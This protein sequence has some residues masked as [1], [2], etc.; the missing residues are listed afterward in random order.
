V[1]LRNGG[2]VGKT[3]VAGGGVGD[4]IIVMT[5][6]RRGDYQ[7]FCRR[8]VCAVVAFAAL[9]A[10]L[11]TAY[12]EVTDGQVRDCLKRAVAQLKRG[13]KSDGHW[14]V[15]STPAMS[16]GSGGVTAL[17]VFALLQ[18]G[19][20]LKD[21]VV[22]KGLRAL[23]GVPD[24]ETYVVSLKVMALAKA[25][26]ISGRP[27]YR[28]EIERGVQFLER[29]QSAIGTW[30]YEARDVEGGAASLVTRTDN[31]NTQMALLGLHEAARA[32]YKVASP[33][34]K[35]SEDYYIRTQEG[36]GSW[37]YRHGVAGLPK[38]GSMTAAGLASLFVTGAQL[39]TATDCG[40][41][42]AKSARYRTHQPAARALAWLAKNYAIDR[43]PA[44]PTGA[45]HHYY[46][47]TLERVGMT[48]G[49]QTI[50]GHDWFREGAEYLVTHQMADGR[51]R[52]S[53][54]RGGGVAR[55]YEL[56]FAILFLAKGHVPALVSKLRWSDTAGQWN[57]NQYDAE[58]L[59]RWIGTRL[60]DRPLSWQT[61]GWS[62]PLE[63]WLKA[64]ILLITGRTAPKFGKK[65]V[66]RL[67]RYVAEGGTLVAI[68]NCDSKEFSE[69]IRKLAAELYP[70]APFG[71]LPKNHPVYSSY[72]KLPPT[73][74]I[75]GL[76]FGCRTSLLLSTKDLSCA[77]ELA[78]GGKSEPGL[79]MGLNIAAYTTA[80]QPLRPRLATVSV[81]EQ[82]VNVKMDRMALYV[83]KVHHHGR[84]WNSRPKA[85]DRLLELLRTESGIKAANRAVPV[86]LTDAKLSQFPVLVM[87]GH[88]DP[89]LTAEEK[90]RLKDYLD[91]GGFLFAEACCGMPAF[92][93]GFRALMAE[94]YPERPLERIGPDDPLLSGEVGHKIGRVHLSVAMRGETP[95]ETSP[96]LEGVTIGDRYGVVYSPLALGPGLDG[97]AT[98]HSRG[99]VAADAR[100]LAVNILLYA[101]RY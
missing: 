83:G 28:K 84:D 59:S 35:R 32:G 93:K 42:K 29:T 21:P 90:R 18:A 96:H 1:P 45:W 92:D 78:A 95:K 91:R 68:A 3:G 41:A 85:M 36:D 75:E 87:S 24:L 71:P 72:E 53:K 9:G 52:R 51:F 65:H 38:S 99:Y 5:R 64:P 55:E 17:A 82:A 63:T 11:A 66:E 57:W 94:L 86:A 69:G 14:E 76:T 25:E 49:L 60:N 34:W 101:L 43:N 37:R 88:Y 2:G 98:F 56:A 4:I 81:S 80:G 19:E 39:Q 61:V 33:V 46:L 54:A 26:Q 20:P 48:G 13:Q 62:D 73:W 22:A 77:W 15:Q 70:N 79:K 10:S 50:G 100:Q 97:V 8:A 47:Y 7:T 16:R 67:R 44:L 31:S 89:S 58:N 27:I 40:C 6:L 23:E 30:G 74:P 12:G